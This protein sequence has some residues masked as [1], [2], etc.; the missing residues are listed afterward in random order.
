MIDY[1]EN[2]PQRQLEAAPESFYFDE[3]RV[4]RIFEEILQTE[5]FEA[6]LE[7]NDTQAFIVIQDDAILYEKYLN[8]VE[9]DSLLMS[10][11]MAK[12]LTTALIGIA[13][14]EGHIGSVDDTITDYLP[15]LINR[16]PQ[17]RE[18]SIRDP[19]MMAAGLDYQEMR[20]GLL[21]GDDVLTTYYPDQR[22][23][24][25]ENTKIVDPPGEYFQ[26]NKYHPLWVDRSLLPVRF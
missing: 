8:G 1:L 13:I 19:M 7:A 15:E 25:L 12:S 24:A 11:S 10:F 5:D 3:G 17:F 16:D 23:L 2:F 9:R 18:I 4:S 6:F 21:N 20:L 26:Y 22:Q 14:A